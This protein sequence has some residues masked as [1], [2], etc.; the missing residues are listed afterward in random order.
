M[1]RCQFCKPEKGFKNPPDNPAFNNPDEHLII[2]RTG[3]HTHIHGPFANEFIIREMIK[4]LLAEAEKN[5]IKFV[6]PT[7][8][9]I[10]D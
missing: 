10:G 5:G 6:M 8:E 9:R 3:S 1:G 7:Q 2:V 4:S